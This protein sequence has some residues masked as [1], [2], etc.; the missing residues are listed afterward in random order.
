[1]LVQE[2]EKITSDDYEKNT[3]DYEISEKLKEEEK[4]KFSKDTEREATKQKLM[5]HTLRLQKG[6][7]TDILKRISLIDERLRSDEISHNSTLR[8]YYNFEEKDRKNY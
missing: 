8:T 4:Q 1:M 5:E 7:L 2:T 3:K 6:S